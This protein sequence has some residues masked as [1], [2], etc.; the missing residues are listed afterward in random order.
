MITDWKK[1]KAKVRERIPAHCFRM[2]LEPVDCLGFDGGTLA[3]S[4]PNAVF[5][6]RLQDRYL[7]LIRE[8]FSS[9]G[10]SGIRIELREGRDKYGTPSPAIKEPPAPPDAK[11]AEKENPSAPVAGFGA[12]RPMKKGR[13]FDDF[14]V[15]N[16]SGFAYSASLA[17]ARGQLGGNSMLYLLSGTG[18]GKSHLSQAVGRHIRTSFP[19][20]GV[21]YATA[22]DFTNE[23]VFSLKS[24]TIAAFKEKYRS[25]CDVLIL[26][27]VHFLSG[28]SATQKEL[29]HTMDYLLDADKKI[30]FSGSLPP[31][32][33]PKLDG[34][35]RSRIAMGLVT[36][37]GRP[38][39]DTRLRILDRKAGAFGAHV[40]RDVAEYLAR[41]LADNVRQLESG[42]Y[43]VTAKAALLDRPVDLDLAGSVVSSMARQKRRVTVDNIRALVCK[44]FSVSEEEI[45]SRSRKRRLV[46]PRQIAMYLSRK[47]T[48][49]PIKKIGQIFNRYHATAI[50]SVNC[51]EAE[52]KHRGVL[53]E[54]VKYLSAKI[55]KGELHTD[56]PS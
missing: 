36:E 25:R 17:L 48:D 7:P 3:L 30:I 16:N 33:I 26:E 50:Y 24:G 19:S 55:K 53:Y 51:V 43:G 54:Q 42:L 28:K 45:I 9:Y 6:R 34:H 44:E 21:Y 4:S 18:L 10:H 52:L 15:G 27:D 31:E 12:G 37:I 29:A 35:V 20:A 41:E 2:W 40:P 14:V 49:Q 38:D 11:P 1:V 39:F 23:L 46:K 13:T 8:I 22:E 56:G 47:Y 32:E 5:T